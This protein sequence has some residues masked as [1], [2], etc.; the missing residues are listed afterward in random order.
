MFLLLFCS[1]DNFQLFLKPFCS[2]NS[3]RNDQNYGN[4]TYTPPIKP[5]IFKKMKNSVMI[6]KPSPKF[7]LKTKTFFPRGKVNATQKGS[8]DYES[9][10]GKEKFS[11]KSP[12]CLLINKSSRNY[13]LPFL[14]GMHCILKGYAINYAYLSFQMSMLES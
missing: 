8:K 4:I 9:N 13:F 7:Q 2:G 12:Y 1:S 3:S 6:T 10:T 5:I 14:Q 11:S